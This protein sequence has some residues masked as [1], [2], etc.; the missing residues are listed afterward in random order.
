MILEKGIKTQITR[1]DDSTAHQPAIHKKQ[2]FRL[3]NNNIELF[4]NLSID[5][6]I[7]NLR[8]IKN[9][10]CYKNYKEIFVKKCPKNDKIYAGAKSVN[11]WLGIY[12]SKKYTPDEWIKYISRPHE[13]N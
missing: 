5:E 12:T 2:L 10:I 3:F 4:K 13:F 9:K 8:I 1:G 6:I 7:V 11:F